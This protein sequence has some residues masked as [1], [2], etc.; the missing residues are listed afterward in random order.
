MDVDT[1]REALSAI[2]SESVKVLKNDRFACLVVGN[3]RGKGGNYNDLVG[4]TVEA[5]ADCGM[6]YYN[7]AILVTP[8]GSLA[9]CAPRSF[10]KG[11][12]LGKA[13][14]NVLVFIKGDGKRAAQHIN[15]SLPK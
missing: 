6:G 10:D 15:E 2:I 8:L 3:Y 7:E 1:F 14:Q 11:R 13:H 4:W 12:K 5:F 9:V